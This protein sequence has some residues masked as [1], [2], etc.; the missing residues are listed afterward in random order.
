M[1]KIIRADFFRLSKNKIYKLCLAVMFVFGIISLYTGYEEGTEKSLENGFFSFLIVAIFACAAF[2]P[3]FLGT[4][5]SDGTLQNK[6]ILGNSRLSV[7]AANLIVCLFAGLSMCAAYAAS[8]ISIGI[9][10]VGKFTCSTELIIKYIVA[11]LLILSVFIALFTALA[12]TISNKA[13]SSVICIML[14][15]L[16]IF[17]GVLIRSALDEPEY[18]DAF[19]LTEN[20]VTV[21]E[22]RQLNPNYLRGIK[23]KVFEFMNDIL[24]GCQTL[25]LVE[26]KINNINFFYVC[27]ILWMLLFTVTGLA[28]FKK[29][30]LK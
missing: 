13:G 4:D 27:D 29:E 24:P 11:S 14:A 25:Q 19:V 15:L 30:D 23:R 26:F 21:S 7:Y 22:D 16:L 2:V 10:A 12:Q 6:L 1:N 9:L 28:V 17:A 20:G 8:Y 5:H 3:M 18:F